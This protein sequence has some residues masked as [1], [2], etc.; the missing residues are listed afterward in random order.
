MAGLPSRRN[1]ETTPTPPLSRITRRRS[2]RKR[3]GCE[4]AYNVHEAAAGCHGDFAGTPPFAFRVF[5]T[6]TF[7]ARATLFI[8]HSL[9]AGVVYGVAPS[10]GWIQTKNGFPSPVGH[11]PV[12][13]ISGAHTLNRRSVSPN[14]E[15]MSKLNCPLLPL[16][17]PT[18]YITS[19]QSHVVIIIIFTSV[20]T[21][22][23]PFELYCCSIVHGR[24]ETTMQRTR[25]A[26]NMVIY[27]YRCR[28]P[29]YRPVVYTIGS[30]EFN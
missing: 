26:Y 5:S 25:S 19:S 17:S 29:H 14:E 6:E 9:L 30:P 3:V 24:P 13:P 15:S 1:W 22:S 7:Y 2:G 21:G 18:R 12:G 10:G 4:R 11:R 23:G 28:Q 27:I 16:P 20:Y 8:I